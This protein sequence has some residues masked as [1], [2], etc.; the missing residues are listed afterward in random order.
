M[1]TQAPKATINP[2]MPTPKPRRAPSFFADFFNPVFDGP[3]NAPIPKPE[4]PS[5]P[6]KCP[7]TKHG[8]IL[9]T[10]ADE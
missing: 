10:E 7:H 3:S 1:R 9:N 8:L 2:I 4:T 5:L 6:P